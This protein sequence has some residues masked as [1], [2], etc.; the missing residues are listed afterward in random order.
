MYNIEKRTMYNLNEKIEKCIEF[1]ED[2]KEKIMFLINNYENLKQKD[3]RKII[4]TIE[5][6]TNNIKNKYLKDSAI[7]EI[8]AISV[9]G[10]CDFILES[11]KRYRE[12]H[13]S[14]ELINICV[15]IL[16]LCEVLKTY[17]ESKSAN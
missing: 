3:V 13:N 7:N 12:F 1:L 5:T 9:E 10:E 6:Y 16:K 15:T 2:A 11:I 8:F 17:K 14:E 4:K